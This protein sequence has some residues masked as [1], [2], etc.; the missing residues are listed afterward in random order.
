M[1]NFKRFTEGFELAQLLRLDKK[2]NWNPLYFYISS[3]RLI[4]GFILGTVFGL[5]VG[6][7]LAKGGWL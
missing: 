5:I 7:L 1:N 2:E 6:C 4:V 3:S